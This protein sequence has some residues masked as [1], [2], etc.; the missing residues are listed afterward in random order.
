MNVSG[1]RVSVRRYCICPEII[2][3]PEILYLSGDNYL[4]GDTVSVRKYSKDEE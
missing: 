1:D 2:I 3:C 4:S